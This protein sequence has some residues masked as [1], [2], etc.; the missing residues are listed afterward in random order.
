MRLASSGPG[1]TEHFLNPD[2]AS[3]T[4]S[5]AES[6]ALGHSIVTLPDLCDSSS[7]ECD[8]LRSEASAKAAAERQRLTSGQ[9]ANSGDPG[10]GGPTGPLGAPSRIPW[11]LSR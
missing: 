3:R 10:P 11:N 6:L 4:A 8:A 5:A 9:P 1:W 2:D 7:G